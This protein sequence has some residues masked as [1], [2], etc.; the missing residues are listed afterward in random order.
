M[1]GPHS[2]DEA[3]VAAAQRGYRDALDQLLRRHYDRIHAVCRRNAGTTRDAD[4]AAQE[5]LIRVVRALDRFDG[6]ATFATWSYRIATNA[7]LDALRRRKDSPSEP[8]HEPRFDGLVTAEARIALRELD[9]LL[10]S[11]PPAERAALVL[12]TIEG[13]SAKEAADALGCSEGAIE[14]RLVRARSTLR[15]RRQEIKGAIDV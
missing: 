4:D 12:V 10:S 15:A 11:L 13:L 7:C 1:I 3:L 6:R 5:A 9:E 8:A 14:Q 2:T